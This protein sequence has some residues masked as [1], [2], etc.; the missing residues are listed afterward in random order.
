MDGL[1]WEGPDKMDGLWWEGPDKT[2]GLWWEG[3]YKMRTTTVLLNFG[4]CAVSLV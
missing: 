4:I 1:W 2:D 3:P